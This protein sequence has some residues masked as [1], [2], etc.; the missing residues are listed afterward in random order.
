MA[1]STSSSA[2]LPLRIVLTG[3]SLVQLYTY[4]FVVLYSLYIGGTDLVLPVKFSFF[5]TVG[6]LVLLAVGDVRTDWRNRHADMSK[7]GL[8]IYRLILEVVGSIGLM[9]LGVLFLFQPL[10]NIDLTGVSIEMKFVASIGVLTL[11]AFSWMV[12][13]DL[14]GFKRKGQLPRV[15][16]TEV[17]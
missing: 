6:V 10:S 13:S 4:V 9:I 8:S 16:D 12:I 2:G 11:I 3:S 15:S 1:S 17:G 5:L 14:L 7:L